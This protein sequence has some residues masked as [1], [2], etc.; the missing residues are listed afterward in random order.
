MIASLLWTA[1]A[2]G[3]VLLSGAAGIMACYGPGLRR[4][5]AVQLSS[6]L[7]VMACCA[8]AAAGGYAFEVDVALALVLIGIPG[9]LVLAHFEER[10]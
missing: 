2:F 7:A 6:F 10:P 1:A 4:L 3:L 5:I 9:T 8:I